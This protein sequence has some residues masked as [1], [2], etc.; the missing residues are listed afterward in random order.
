MNLKLTVTNKGTTPLYRLYAVTKSDNG[1]FDN[2]ELVLGKIDPGKSKTASVPLGWCDTEGHKPGSTQQLPKDAPRVCRIPR[3]A[4]NRADGIKVHFEEAR[5]AA[6]NDAELRVTTKALDR[7]IFAF[8]YDIADNRKGNGDGRLQNDEELTMFVTVK[9][10][11]KGKSFETQANLRNLS[12]DGLLLHEGRF[13][14][15]NMTGRIQAPLVHLRR[16]KSARGSKRVGS[17]SQIAISVNRS[18][19]VR[20][21]GPLRLSGSSA[22]PER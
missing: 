6:P 10:V 1:M 11:G 18:S 22:T 15:S 8:A 9:N 17:R 2:K 5:G 20:I 13:D 3:D 19:K 16:A 12:G 21:P 14:I 4:L 7:P